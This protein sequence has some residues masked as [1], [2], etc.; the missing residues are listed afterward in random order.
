MGLKDIFNGFLS[1]KSGY[2]LLN[3]RLNI[4]CK[5]SEK[6]TALLIIKLTG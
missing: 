5:N 2:F 6:L 3:N 1:Q 4:S